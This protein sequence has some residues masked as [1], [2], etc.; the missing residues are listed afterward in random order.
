MAVD[1]WGTW[2]KGLKSARA[3]RPLAMGVKGTIIPHNGP[4][5]AFEVVGFDPGV[6]YAFATSLPLARLTV[7]RTIT[8]T[9]PTR[10]RHDV[11]F[12]GLLGGF[13]A[14]RFGPGFRAALPPTMETLI[15][16]AEG[17]AP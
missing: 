17:R 9:S 15:A 7:T 14:G 2:D 4:D 8:G 6:S 11:A 5:A 1:T 10:L 13:W 3:E 16:R 12:S